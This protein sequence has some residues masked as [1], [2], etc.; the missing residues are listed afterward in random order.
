M[1]QP[2][3][4]SRD[5]STAMEAS[6]SSSFDARTRSTV[7]RSARAYASTRAHVTEQVW[8]GSNSSL[9]ADIFAIEQAR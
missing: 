6:S 7:F 3:R 8:S 2:V 9:V 1:T 4:I 5:S